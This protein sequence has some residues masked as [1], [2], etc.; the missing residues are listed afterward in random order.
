MMKSFAI[1]P[2]IIQLDTGKEFCENFHLGEGDLI[3]SNQYIYEPYL[4]E[5]CSGVTTVFVENYG[6]GEPSDEMLESICA[7]IKVQEFNRVFGIGGGTVLDMA[8]L[9]ALE[10]LMPVCDLYAHKFPAIRNKKL[11]LVP[12]TCGTGSEMTNIS[13]LELKSLKTKMGLAEDALFAD[14]AVLISELLEGLPFRYF[15]TSSIDALVHAVESYLSPK[16]TAFSHMYSVEAVRMIL[17]GYKV[18]V[19]CGEEARL[20]LLSE[21]QIASTYAGIAFGNAGCAAVHAM[22][23]PLGAK[24]HVAHGESNYVLFTEVLKAYQRLK[25]EGRI[26]EL[27]E[28]LAGVL[29]CKEAD[30]YDALEQLLNNLCVKKQLREY[31]VKRDELHEFTKSVMDGQQR[32]MVNNYTELSE[33]EVYGIYQKLW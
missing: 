5:Y 3:L 17:S 14:K 10:T 8:K 13:I 11:F 29:Q 18:I 6:L 32:L 23:Y 33:N 22:S 27:K 15:V 19:R 21:F 20:P 31:G 16:A 12:T 4:S 30:V 28:L 7:D 2:Q 1:E 24:Y 25:P 26:Q 9:F